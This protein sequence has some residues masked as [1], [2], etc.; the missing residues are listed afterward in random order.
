MNDSLVTHHPEIDRAKGWAILAVICIHARWL[1]GTVVF[2]HLINRAVPVFLILFGVTSEVW[3][4]RRESA[5]AT[6]GSIALTWYRARLA[7]LFPPVWA[8]ATAWWVVALAT[9][10]AHTF[11]WGW[12]DALVTYAGY[13]PWIGAR[14]FV[15]VVLELVVL[16][17]LLRALVRRIG[18]WAALGFGAVASGISVWNVYVIVEAGQTWLASGVPEPGWYYQW[19][20]APRVFWHVLAGVALAPLIARID[21]RVTW[22]TGAL[23]CLGPLLAWI[24]RGGPDDVFVAPMRVELVMAAIDVPLTVAL[25]GLCRT[26]LPQPYDRALAWCG[27]ATWGL[28]L[29]HILVHEV[30][31]LLGLGPEFGPAGMRVLYGVALF[32]AGVAIV[33]TARRARLR[34][35][36]IAASRHASGAT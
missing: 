27:T 25:V 24:A 33:R 10:G 20:F 9:G 17:P 35:A 2:E 30:V 28:Y 4:H 13:S 29:G 26:P 21:A 22:F 34:W 8:M 16:F 23:V 1:E 36:A 6:N 15:T 3:W 7:R 18:P 5:G 12:G 11:A 19:I 14:W 32:G 31:H